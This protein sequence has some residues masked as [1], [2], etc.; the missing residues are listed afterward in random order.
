MSVQ[1]A[2]PADRPA[3]SFDAWLTLAREY[4]S[5]MYCW[6]DFTGHEC[7]SA[8]QAKQTPEEF[9]DEL[10]A[11]FNLDSYPSINFGEHPQ[12]YE[13]ERYRVAP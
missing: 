11:K 2:Q 13:P 4:A 10:A 1:I 3:A 12:G 5:L 9:V 8:F 6:C 7:R